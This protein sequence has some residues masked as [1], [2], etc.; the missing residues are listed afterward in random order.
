MITIISCIVL[1]LAFI[2]IGDFSQR[3]SR[4]VVKPFI[5][6]LSKSD[7]AYLIYIA[8]LAFFVF[9]LSVY[10]ALFVLGYNGSNLPVILILVVCTMIS[11]YIS[12][13]ICGVRLY[14][15]EI[16][17]RALREITKDVIKQTVLDYRLFTAYF[18]VLTEKGHTYL[19][20]VRYY[21][22]VVDVRRKG[23]VK[24]QFRYDQDGSLTRVA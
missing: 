13:Q 4:G 22:Q 18:Q 14:C 9:V 15:I 10:L 20:T 6:R 2:L 8:L 17:E 1:V 16:G 23:N 7:L 12:Y 11:Y 24:Y 19:V 5:K 21:Y 3:L